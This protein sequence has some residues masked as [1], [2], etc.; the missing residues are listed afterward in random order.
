MDHASSTAPHAGPGGAPAILRGFLRWTR[1]A[2]A[3]ARAQGTRALARAYLH[4]ELDPAHRRDALLVLTA[5][6]DD[7]S[8]AVRLALADVLG[9]SP[10]APRALI[11]A[12]AQDQPAVAAL[13]LGA[14]P[15]LAD[16]DLV[17]AVALGCTIAQDAVAGRASVSAAV[18]AAVAEVGGVQACRTLCVN[19]GAILTPAAMARMVARH[20]DDPDL[21]R[22]LLDRA[23]LAP[24]L[25]HDLVV[26]TAR[27]LAAFLV[28][29][30]W[31][32]ADGAARMLRD[33]TDR[34]CLTIAAG[35]EAPDA[36]TDL[37]AHL[38]AA[39]RL[40][41]AL[42]LRSTVSGDPALFEAAASRLSGVPLARVAGLLRGG[43]T[44]GFG[45][46]YGR[47]GL[48]PV[49]C[50]VFQAALFPTG[51]RDGHV[52]QRI[53]RA[54]QACAASGDP[55]L[56]STAALL[57]RWDAE[58]ARDEARAFARDVHA[59]D[60]GVAP[61]RLPRPSDDAWAARTAA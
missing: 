51:D 25:R 43:R 42:L 2:P 48:P 53:A 31:M 47:T 10:A 35:T 22:L 39:G 28:E 45:A 9:P 12:L 27:A 44:L 29:R 19:P 49:L 24:G 13:V 32:S 46:L 40:T 1:S 23:D 6:L 5:L 52:R 3:D 56:G 17:D 61:P 33:A 57:R 37:V 38:L 15:L 60:G 58:A 41:P 21:R 20:G 30:C 36:P 50:P 11:T 59:A 14:S 7:P 16:A 55:S 54:L 26:A 8:P 18:A 4:G 34:A